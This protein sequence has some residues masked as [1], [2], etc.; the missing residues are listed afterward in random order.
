MFAKSAMPS[1]LRGFCSG[2]ENTDPPGAARKMVEQRG[3][4]SLTST[5]RTPEESSDS[6]DN[7]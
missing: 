2:R 7:T 4:E 5:L 3:I 1:E 6:N